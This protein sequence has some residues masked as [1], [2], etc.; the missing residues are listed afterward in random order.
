MIFLGNSLPIRE[1]DAAAVREKRFHVFA[2]RGVNG[3][4]GLI[5]T[6]IGLADPDK[7]NWAVI[8]DLSA[9]YDLSGPWANRLR[10]I[11][12]LNIVILN[13]RGGR[14]FSRIFNNR[15]FENEHEVE[16]SGLAAL[17]GWDYQKI[18]NL[19]ELNPALGPRIIE[20]V[21]DNSQTTEFWQ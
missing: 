14:I 1:W 21:P 2:N 8:G 11:K 15:L 13:N 18:E 12:S 20:I 9:L 7:E 5:S 17:W 16:F 3:I 19:D 10:K 6:F 4:D